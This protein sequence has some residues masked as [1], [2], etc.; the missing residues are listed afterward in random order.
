MT[1][2][3]PATVRM[4]QRANRAFGRVAP[5]LT[6]RLNHRLFTTPRRFPPREWEAAFES[7]GARRR[8]VSGISVL[9]AGDGPLVAL[10]HGWEGRATQLAGFAPSLIAQGYRVIAIDGPAH[11]H[12]HGRRADPFWFARAIQDVAADVR[13]LHGAIGHSLGGG[14]IAIAIAEGLPVARVALIGSPASLHDAL[15][16]FATWMELPPRAAEYFAGEIR[17][18]VTSRSHGAYDLAEVMRQ[19]TVPA[20]VVHARDDRE[21]PHADGERIATVWPGAQRLLVND[22]GHRRIL[23]DTTVIRTIVAFLAQQVADAVNRAGGA[24][25]PDH[26]PG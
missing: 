6:A 25:A 8:L 3:P 13:P 21:V 4:M 19:I 11:G 24:P 15:L 5:A 10:V 16:R 9:E 2:V 12:S 14:S 20:M 23:R 7:M 26:P 17:R 22:L 1:R 18:Q